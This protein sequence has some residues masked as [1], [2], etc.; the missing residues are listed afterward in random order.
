MEDWAT[1]W[2]MKFNAKKCYIL[3]I[4]NK[5][6]NKFY[7]LNSYILKH[8]DNNPYLGL[9]ISNNL[10]WSTH[11]DQVSKKASST[12]GFIQRNLKKCPAHCKKTAYISLVRSTLEYGATVWDPHLE[13]DVHKLEK[14]QRKAVQ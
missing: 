1:T 4:S 9:I 14:I 2:G 7:Q 13:K 8:V 3:S 6:T 12:L 11:I 5:G 10:K